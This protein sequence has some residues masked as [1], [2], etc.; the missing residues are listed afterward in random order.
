MSIPVFF[1]K[2]WMFERRVNEKTEKIAIPHEL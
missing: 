1:V 2:K